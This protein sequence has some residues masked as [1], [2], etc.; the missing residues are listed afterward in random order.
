MMQNELDTN[1]RVN[2]ILVS[3]DFNEDE[4]SFIK[5]L[6]SLASLLNA[7]LCGLFN[8]NSELQQIANLPFSREITF[9]TAIIRSLNRENITRHLKQHHE[10]LR[11]MISEL[12]QLSNVSCSFKTTQGSRIEAILSESLNYELIVIL[13][14]KY[15]SQQS[16]HSEL[17][18]EKIN[19][20]VVY[21]DR[22]EQS[23]ISFYIIH[24][25]INSGNLKELIIL[26]PDH[27]SEKQAKQLYSLDS[28]DVS[29]RHIDAYEILNIVSL[30]GVHKAG[31]VVLPLENKLF[32]QPKEIRQMLDI[33]GCPLLLVR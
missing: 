16:R 27:A 3:L 15:S 10:A 20:T 22:S 23:K 32:S 19:P 7:D 33:L 2:R 31:L 17:L 8:E 5:P 4:M 25:L 1:I 24:S 21:H 11:V 30:A 14:E 18:E 9:P 6:I 13:P 29:F 28:I 12:S 26:T